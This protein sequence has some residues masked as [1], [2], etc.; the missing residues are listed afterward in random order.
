MK[1]LKAKYSNGVLNPMEKLPFSEGVELT[2]SILSPDTE[3]KKDLFAKAAGAWKG[4]VDAK[5]LIND[6]Y[7]DRLVSGRKA[8]K[9][10]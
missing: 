9:L 8:P 7:A 6:I 3:P 4:K 1:T 5:K 2:I 10:K